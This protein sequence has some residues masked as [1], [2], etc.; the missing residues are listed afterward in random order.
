[1]LINSDDLVQGTPASAAKIKDINVLLHHENSSTTVLDYAARFAD[2][3]RASLTAIY[4]SPSA[5]IPV[6]LFGATTPDFHGGLT[7][8]IRETTQQVEEEF[9]RIC[10]RY[11]L[12]SKWQCGSGEPW[13]VF[14]KFA[15]I[16]DLNIMGQSSGKNMLG[17]NR[18]LNDVIFG[19]GRPLLIAP[20]LAWTGKIGERFVIAWDESRPAARAVHDV[21]PLLQATEEVVDVV[22]LSSQKSDAE[23]WCESQAAPA[24]CHNLARHGV[25]AN[26]FSPPPSCVELGMSLVNLS[27]IDKADLLV[28][29][30]W[31]H[32]RTREYIFGGVTNTVVEYSNV[33]VFL[34]H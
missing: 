3:Y 19:S 24:L 23:G 15:R 17:Q 10:G 5:E 4:A 33:P 34:S 32:H 13:Q 30:A 14:K 22:T 1:M 20:R 9:Q 27:V 8:N 16:C 6:S 12:K 18:V 28:M 31:G 11:A 21:L 2:H 7:K 25:Q 29:G 26:A